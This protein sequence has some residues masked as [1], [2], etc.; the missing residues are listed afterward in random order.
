MDFNNSKIPRRHSRTA[1]SNRNRF[2][3]SQAVA[4]IQRIATTRA[5]SSATSTTKPP[6][7]GAG[8]DDAMT[9]DF[10]E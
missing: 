1:L 4:H 9:S 3:S 2:A 5:T 8:T 10:T 6:L 7:T